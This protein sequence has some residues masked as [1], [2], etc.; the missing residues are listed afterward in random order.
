MTPLVTALSWTNLLRLGLSQQE[1][2]RR[3]A[4]AG[5]AVEDHRAQAIGRQQ[6]PQQLAFAQKL[7][8]ADELVERGGPHPRRQRL[9]AAPVRRFAGFEQRHRSPRRLSEKAP[10]IFY[11]AI[12]RADMHARAEPWRWL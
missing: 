3:L 11:A 5:R 8:L 2:E 12:R 9:R 10:L 1:G 6:S 7:L 4:G